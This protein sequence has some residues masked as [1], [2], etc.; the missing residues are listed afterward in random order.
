MTLVKGA[1]TYYP[2]ALAVCAFIGQIALFSQSISI[3]SALAVSITAIS[4]LRNLSLFSEE[5]SFKIDYAINV[6]SLVANLIS[7]SYF[8]ALI[9]VIGICLTSFSTKDG[10]EIVTSVIYLSVPKKDRPE[11]S[12]IDDQITTCKRLITLWELMDKS[13]FDES[14][15][16]LHTKYVTPQ[17]KKSLI[18]LLWG[19][20]E[21][22]N[23]IKYRFAGLLRLLGS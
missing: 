8:K 16:E 10:K 13:V 12:K 15:H 21:Q 18:L 19:M 5:T 6:T 3:A 23:D 4:I 11:G 22:I 9:K 2:T 1:R 7:K 14:M 17:L 20:N